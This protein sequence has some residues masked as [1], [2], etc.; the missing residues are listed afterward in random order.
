MNA[1]L[2]VTLKWKNT[3]RKF[4]IAHQKSDLGCTG[5]ECIEFENAKSFFLAKRF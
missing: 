5:S 3:G 4:P 1:F 2:V